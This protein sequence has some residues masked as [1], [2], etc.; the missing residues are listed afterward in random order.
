ML[1]KTANNLEKCFNGLKLQPGYSIQIS[2][3]NQPIGVGCFFFIRQVSY[4]HSC[5]VRSLNLYMY[6][7]W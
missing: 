5:Y 4:S 3:M 7:M 2:L 1:R 6:M